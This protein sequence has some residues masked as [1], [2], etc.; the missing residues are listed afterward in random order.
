VGRRI[1]DLEAPGG[2]PT[3]FQRKARPEPGG[4]RAVADELGVTPRKKA[5]TVG[6]ILKGRGDGGRKDLN[7]G[8]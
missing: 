5:P 3:D 1:A 8:R 2:R 6:S 4:V 7:R